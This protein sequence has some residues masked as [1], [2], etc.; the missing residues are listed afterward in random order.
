MQFVNIKQKLNKK[1]YTCFWTSCISRQKSYVAGGGAIID[2]IKIFVKIK[3]HLTCINTKSTLT[4]ERRF[5]CNKGQHPV[6]GGNI[7]MCTCGSTTSLPSLRI[8]LVQSKLSVAQHKGLPQPHK[9]IF[10]KHAKMGLDNT[11][12][13]M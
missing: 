1:L 7:K 9:G 10:P 6:P 4:W 2:S 5:I 3:L 13:P 8:I 12:M 11:C